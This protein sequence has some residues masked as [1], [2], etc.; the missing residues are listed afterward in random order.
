MKIGT[1]LLVTNLAVIALIG[2][3]AA[4]LV[5]AL[6]ERTVRENEQQR[7]E[8]Q[9]L[10]QAEFISDR[11]N[12]LA[13]GRPALD[14]P[15]TLLT[16]D[17]VQEL[18]AD[19]V[20]LV[21]DKCI[22]Q[23]SSR[24]GLVRARLENCK[25]AGATAKTLRRPLARIE[26]VGTFIL[27]QAPLSIE[28]AD[29][30]DW[31]VAMIRD[32]SY[33]QSIAKPI[34]KRLIFVLLLGVVFSLF[35][36]GWISR[37]MVKRLQT[38]GAAARALAGGDLKRR[39]PEEGTDEITDLAHHFNH[40]AERLDALV[41]G[42]RKS[43][44]ARRE[45]LMLVGHDL[46]TPMTSIAGFA[47]ALRDGVVQGEEKK[48]RYY[49]IIATEA[50]RLNRM[51]NDLF[52]MAKLEAGQL[53]LRMQALLVA[54]WLTEFAEGFRPVAEGAGARVELAVSAEAER[55]RIYADRDRLDQVLGNL[56][57][58]AVRYSPA[59]Q[60]VTIVAAVDGDDL[61]IEVSDRGPGIPPADT[62]KVFDRFY[63]GAD[64]GNGGGHKGA[65]LGLS[66][67]KSLVEAHGGQVG[68]DSPPGQGATFWFR[69]KRVN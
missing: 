14:R 62:Q 7:L 56:A 10:K 42:L 8:Q 69:L 11:V 22:I 61:L 26:G 12:R 39:V 60:A 59:G 57:G 36:A 66:I 54:P 33:I 6:V 34:E 41:E 29:L 9:V 51:V 13:K 31:S 19:D 23:R 38:T 44:Q 47:E 27:A 32:V 35:I 28:S 50:G 63:Q 65:G 55:A 64:P 43:E 30:A 68:V 46:R 1:K 24:P 5:P 40:M 53:E 48:Q 16:L 15:A 52:D 58:N 49:Q 18:L 2:I 20:A 4:V 21:D 25:T 37:E 17:A 67:V 3:L 45:L